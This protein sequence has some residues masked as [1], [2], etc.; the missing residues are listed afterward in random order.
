[1]C[2]GTLYLR[3][4]DGSPMVAVIAARRI[5]SDHC[6][7]WDIRSGQSRMAGFLSDCSS[8]SERDFP[9]R[10]AESDKIRPSDCTRHGI[11][12]L[13]QRYGR[14]GLVQVAN[15][16]FLQVQVGLRARRP[17]VTQDVGDQM[18]QGSADGHRWDSIMESWAQLAAE[19]I[20]N[21]SSAA[22]P[23]G[24]WAARKTNACPDAA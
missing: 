15:L 22:T 9:T 17:Q 10:A 6:R 4:A 19:Q 23:S 24:V 20:W 21:G 12:E 11:L 16:S 2:K 3:K 18:H 13:G 5:G 1:M 8:A 14:S 7:L